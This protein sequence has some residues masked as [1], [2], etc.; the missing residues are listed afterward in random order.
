[1]LR[2]SNQRGGDRW[3]AYGVSMG[4]CK[5]KRLLG[6]PRPRWEV[7]IKLDLKEIGAWTRFF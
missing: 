5:G 3:N 2:R 1:V 7:N 4:K 6:R